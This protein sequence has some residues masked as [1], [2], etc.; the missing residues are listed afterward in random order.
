[1]A[2][3]QGEVHSAP[4]AVDTALRGDASDLSLIEGLFPD[5]PEITTSVDNAIDALADA[6]YGLTTG[7]DN[8]V[9]AGLGR[10]T[11]YLAMPTRN[12]GGPTELAGCAKAEGPGQFDRV[13]LSYFGSVRLGR[14]CR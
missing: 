7:N 8:Q 12:C 10:A 6:V 4:S 1:M 11:A 2:K 5:D 3:A 9:A 14:V 13:P